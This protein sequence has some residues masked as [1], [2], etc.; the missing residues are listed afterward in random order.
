MQE[1]GLPR[2][3]GHEWWSGYKVRELLDVALC[4]WA[5]GTANAWLR[6]SRG[7]R[8]RWLT[9]KPI[10]RPILTVEGR[11]PALENGGG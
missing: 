7:S 8:F 2:F 9:S 4:A 10:D 11:V 1:L 3:D 6:R 5:T